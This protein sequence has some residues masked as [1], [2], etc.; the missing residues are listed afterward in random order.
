MGRRGRKSR[1][2][3]KNIRRIVLIALVV[4]LGSVVLQ[5]G[6]SFL[7]QSRNLLSGMNQADTSLG[8]NLILVN[9][10]YAIPD[11]YELELTELSNGKKVDS[12][13][14]P[15]LHLPRPPASV[16]SWDTTADFFH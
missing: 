16:H 6:G 3:Q 13:I 11:D 5:T 8:W 9:G 4:I 1:Y 15:A 12:R 7:R 10:D 2:I 14:Y